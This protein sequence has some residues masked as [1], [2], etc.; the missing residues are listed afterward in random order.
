MSEAPIDPRFAEFDRLATEVEHAPNAKRA[1]VTRN[2]RSVCVERGGG[3][4]G[5]GV[6]GWHHVRVVA[7]WNAARRCWVVSEE[8]ES[9]NSET[10]SSTSERELGSF[11]TPAPAVA[12]LRNAFGI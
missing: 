11:D 1:I 9:A 7:A 12:C 3:G 5:P 4:A 10:G 8:T 6:Y 2:S